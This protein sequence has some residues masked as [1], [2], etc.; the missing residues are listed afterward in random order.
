MPWG[1]LW[2]DVELGVIVCIRLGFGGVVCSRAVGVEVASRAAA[3]GGRVSR[4]V[5]EHRVFAQQ[6][7]SHRTYMLF[8]TTLATIMVLILIIF[9]IFITAF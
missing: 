7:L 1:W 5:F 4:V 2:R 8:F 6:N 9:I 3:P